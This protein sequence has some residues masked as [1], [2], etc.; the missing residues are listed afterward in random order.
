LTVALRAAF[1]AGMGELI[2]DDLWLLDG[3]SFMAFVPQ[4][5]EKFDDSYISGGENLEWHVGNQVFRVEEFAKTW[6]SI[7]G[8]SGAAERTLCMMASLLF[9]DRVAWFCL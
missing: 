6:P 4:S 2:D 3:C 1:L 7:P 5:Y 8:P 9:P